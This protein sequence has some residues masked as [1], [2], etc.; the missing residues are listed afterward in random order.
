MKIRSIA[1]D[2]HFTDCY[3]LPSVYAYVRDAL[4]LASFSSSIFSNNMFQLVRIMRSGGGK[5]F[6]WRELNF[7]NE[8]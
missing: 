2:E 7:R 1:N 5:E 6:P 3:Y 8:I 4:L